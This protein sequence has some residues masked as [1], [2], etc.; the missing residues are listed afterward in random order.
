MTTTT[1]VVTTA[2]ATTTTSR[3]RATEDLC[4]VCC[5]LYRNPPTVR[6]AGKYIASR[7]DAFFV[8]TT[9]IR[10]SNASSGCV[11]GTGVK[12]VLAS[13]RNTYFDWHFGADCLVNAIYKRFHFPHFV[14]LRLWPTRRGL[15]IHVH[16]PYCT[17]YLPQNKCSFPPPFLLIPISPSSFLC[18]A[19][20]LCHYM[21]AL[22]LLA[23]LRVSSDH[24]RKCQKRKFR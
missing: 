20:C 12:T 1:T 17:L 16:V 9:C 18:C 6:G 13:F 22:L 7:S 3:W 14:F 23:R 21:Y 10:W 19:M 15:S 5:M 11:R 8:F 24:H 4:V 2:T